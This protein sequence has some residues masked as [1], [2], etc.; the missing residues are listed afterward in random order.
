VSFWLRD[1]AGGL[2]QPY[3]WLVL[4][5]TSMATQFLKSIQYQNGR[6][7]RGGRS[8]KAPF[9]ENVFWLKIGIAIG[10]VWGQD[11]YIDQGGFLIFLA[12]YRVSYLHKC[13]CLHARESLMGWGWLGGWVGWGSRYLICGGT[14]RKAVSTLKWT[15]NT[16]LKLCLILRYLEYNCC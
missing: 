4:L 11:N 8:R 1:P 3:W 7:K 12:S 14:F 15:F 6:K 13:G 16:L 9:L 5:I 10:Y 2:Y